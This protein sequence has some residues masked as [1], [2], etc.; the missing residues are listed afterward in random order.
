LVLKQLW[1]DSLSACLACLHLRRKYNQHIAGFRHSSLSRTHPSLCKTRRLSCSHGLAGKLAAKSYH[2]CGCQTQ[3][4]Y[5]HAGIQDSHVSKWQLTP[6]STVPPAQLSQELLPSSLK[7]QLC[8][9]I[10]MP[11]LRLASQ[12]EHSQSKGRH[13]AHSCEAGAQVY[14]LISSWHTVSF[15]PNWQLHYSNNVESLACGP[16]NHNGMQSVCFYRYTC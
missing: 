15:I 14:G 10:T 4:A 9:T 1:L 3:L 6:P 2:V 12:P 7:H 5:W 13:C 11:K 16:A 8:Q